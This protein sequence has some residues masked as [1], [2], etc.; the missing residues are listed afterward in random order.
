MTTLKEKRAEWL[1]EHFQ[2]VTQRSDR[3]FALFGILLLSATA[4]WLTPEGAVELP[5]IKVTAGR[6][7]LIGCVLVAALFTFIAFCGNFDHGEFTLNQLA[8]ELGCDYEDLWLVDTHPTIVDFAKYRRQEVA[9]KR[10]ILGRLSV[11]MLYPLILIAALTWL[12]FIWAHE[13]FFR[14]MTLLES[15]PYLIVVLMLYPIA[16]RGYEYFVRRWR[17]FI[18]SE[19][20]RRNSRTAGSDASS[21]ATLVL[22]GG[23]GDAV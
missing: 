14:E 19:K 1:Y 6:Q 17:A 21:E 16:H 9:D 20:A 12:M 10:G 2:A 3:Y 4:L 5:F 8:A 7:L 13:S 15:V 22:P 11:A 18:F 23:D